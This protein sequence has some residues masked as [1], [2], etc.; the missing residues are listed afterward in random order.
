VL[1][2]EAQSDGPTMQHMPA[3]IDT[4]VADAIRLAS[5]QDII[6]VEA[7]G[8]GYSDLAEWEDATGMHTLD[9][10]NPGEFFDSGAIMVGACR[11]AVEGTPSGHTRS[12]WSNYGARVD[13]YAWGQDVW[14]TSGSVGEN[15]LYTDSF[16]A[17]SSATAII[18]G[19]CAVVQS[20]YKEQN[21]GV[22][23]TPAQMRAILS[24]PAKGTPQTTQHIPSKPIGVMPDLRKIMP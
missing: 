13:C 16:S 21:G 8:N 2:L 10:G 1:V 14:T 4:L 24:D 15:D 6:V 12:A 7:A 9:R 18:A 17:T 20:W 19:V 11:S 22:P 5:S 23:M 3:E